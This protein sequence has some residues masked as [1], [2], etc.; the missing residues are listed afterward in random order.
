MIKSRNK[1]FTNNYVY[2]SLYIVEALAITELYVYINSKARR[3]L[4][5]VSTMLFGAFAVV[6]C[7]QFVNILT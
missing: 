3:G 4:S 1:I 7:F 2:F 5:Y 6:L